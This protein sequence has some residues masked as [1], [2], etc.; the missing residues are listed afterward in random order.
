M[1]WHGTWYGGGGGDITVVQLGGVLEADV[2]TLALT[3]EI[4][5]AATP[6]VS[7]AAVVAELSEDRPAEVV[8]VVV[9][10]DA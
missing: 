5:A 7:S 10:A 9:E 3:A 4:A 2:R 1:S 8:A 6:V